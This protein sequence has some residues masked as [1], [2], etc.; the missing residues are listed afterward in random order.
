M[1]SEKGAS[2]MSRQLIDGLIIVAVLVLC[3]THLYAQG[4]GGKRVLQP[5]QPPNV[6]AAG[7]RV[8]PPNGP[9]GQPGMVGGPGIGAPGVH[10][11]AAYGTAGQRPAPQRPGPR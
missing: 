2:H 6:H 3:A 5:N 4:M 11:G 10:P 7:P 9:V 8:G 1:C